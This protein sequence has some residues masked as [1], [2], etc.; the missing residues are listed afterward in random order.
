M[1][2]TSGPFSSIA[3]LP[4]DSGSYVDSALTAPDAFTHSWYYRC[5]LEPRRRLAWS[6]VAGVRLD[7]QAPTTLSNIPSA[8]QRASHEVTLSA[9]DLKSGVATTQYSF[10]PAGPMRAYAPFTVATEGLNPVYFRSVDRAGNSESTKTATLRL[11]KQPPVSDDDA[12]ATYT[13][14]AEVHLT[15]TD[16]LSGVAAS[17][18]RID[19]GGFA[20][21]DV[22]TTSGL[23][24]HVLDYRSY[25]VG[26][27]REQTRT[28]DSTS[29]PRTPPPLSPRRTST[30]VAQAFFHR[31]DVRDDNGPVPRPTTASTAERRDILGYPDSR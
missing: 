13:L 19:G 20:P 22:A 26:G 30:R 4:A 18:W 16:T 24:H 11:D 28:V 21:G 14:A 1:D 7:T 6:T 31:D 27:N 25:D 29:C 3:T 2:S 10:S 8:W 9:S 15:A 12:V 23:G 5:V 17:E